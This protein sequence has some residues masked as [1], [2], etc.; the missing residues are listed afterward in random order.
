MKETT[1]PFHRCGIVVSFMILELSR[2][3]GIV[4]SF[5]IL[6]LSLK[7]DIV[8]SFM[9]LELSRM[10]HEINHYSSPAEEF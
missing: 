5:M 8:V 10:Y 2:K 6:E 4:V 3:C 1:I 7:C 9:I